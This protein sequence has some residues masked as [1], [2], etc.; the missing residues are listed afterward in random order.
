VDAIEVSYWRYYQ[1]VNDVLVMRG[2]GHSVVTVEGFSEPA[3]LVFEIGSGRLKQVGETTL[4]GAG[5]N[6]RVSF[7]PEGDSWYVAVTASSL[8]QPAWLVGD[9]GSDL[10]DESQQADYVVIAPPDMLGPVQE[11]ADYRAGQ[12]MSTKVVSL[13]DIY[14]EFNAGLTSPEAIKAFLTYAYE[15][16]ASPSPGYVVL[17]GEGSLDY[18]NHRGYGDSVVPPLLVGTPY[19]LY[20]ADN[21]LVDVDDDGLPEMAIGRLPVLSGAEL[22][23]LIGKIKAYESSAGGGWQQEVL[24]VADD[25]D[26]EAGHFPVDSDV[27]ANLVPAGYNVQKV[28]ITAE[29]SASEARSELLS[30]LQ[31]GLRLVN[32]IGHGAPDRLA[33]EGLLRVSDVSGLWNGERLPV[34]AGMTCLIGRYENP[35]SDSLSERLVLQPDGGAIAVWS[36]TGMSL[37]AEARIL[38]QTFFEALFAAEQPVLGVTLLQ[39]QQAYK[40][41]G[42]EQF[43]LDIYNLLGDP[44]LRVR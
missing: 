8:R 36:P 16:W 3:V 41:R 34:L 39:A 26:I 31:A 43:M 24:M 10:K 33:S 5:G 7:R 14:D 25:V 23:A 29:R 4:D 21:R 2:A 20:A 17:V 19:G 9:T 38:D 30:G 28:Y 15:H 11:L 32:Y 12:G 35:G 13:A 6:Y 1:A 37:N 22:S 40:N 42:N 44:A 18:K 27:V